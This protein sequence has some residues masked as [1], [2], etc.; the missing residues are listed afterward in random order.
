MTKLTGIFKVNTTINSYVEIVKTINNYSEYILINNSLVTIHN[1]SI[2]VEKSFV[3]SHKDF[4]KSIR[5]I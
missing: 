2:F 5:S 4:F 3:N 1:N